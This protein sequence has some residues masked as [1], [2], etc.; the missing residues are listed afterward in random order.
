MEGSHLQI[1]T[2]TKDL[3]DHTYPHGYKVIY[4]HSYD[5][6]CVGWLVYRLK[7]DVFRYDDEEFDP[8]KSFDKNSP[9]WFQYLRE[10]E[11]SGL[12][13]HNIEKIKDDLE[14]MQ[15]LGLVTESGQLV[16]VLLYD[17]DGDDQ[18]PFESKQQG[19]NGFGGNNPPTRNVSL[20]DQVINMEKAAREKITHIE[21]YR[22]KEAKDFK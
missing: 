3:L 7:Q 5:S 14:P 21:I 4:G 1:A 15:I 12:G 9:S 16:H 13:E 8:R 18:M 22:L 17:P 11:T 2:R 19:S 20:Y 10:I 6:N